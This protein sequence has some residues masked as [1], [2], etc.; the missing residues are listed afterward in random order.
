MQQ[1]IFLTKM[2]KEALDK[3]KQQQKKEH[4]YSEVEENKKNYTR[5]T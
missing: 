4:K 5:K 3:G 1:S 2:Q